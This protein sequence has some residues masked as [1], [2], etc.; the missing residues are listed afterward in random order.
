MGAKINKTAFKIFI[1]FTLSAAVIATLLLAIN[2]LG[3]SII[4]T[5]F[6]T[7]H[8]NSPEYILETIQQSLVK[9]KSGFELSNQ[10]ILGPDCWCILIDENGDITWSEHM[11]DDIPSHYTLNDI[12]KMTKWF[13][14]D[15]PVYV[16][17]SDYG[18]LVL[19]LPKYSVG[20]YDMVY[21]VEWIHSLP[22]KALG[23]LVLN[24]F[25]A[26][27][28]AF[29]FGAKLYHRVQILIN[30]INDLSKEKA[31][32]LKE[33]GIFRELAQ[34]INNT[35][36]AIE[37]KNLALAQR[38][39]AR[40]NWIS[41]ISH[42]I[43]TPLSLIM[44][45]SEALLECDSLND[46]NQ[47]RTESI[48]AQSIKIKKLIEDLNLTSS[49]EYDMQPLKKN[50][51]LLCPLIRRIATDILNS[52]LADN[53]IIDLDIQDEKAVISGDENL[54][55]RAIFNLLNNSIT[56]NKNGCE[57]SIREYTEGKTV[58]L[59]I[60]DNGIGIPDETLE[61]I[62]E[63]PKSAHGLGLP[64]AYR[65][66]CAHGGRFKAMNHNGFMVKI[67]LPKSFL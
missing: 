43:R 30:G 13:L 61:H 3:F 26:A 46:E 1:C 10:D 60:S 5:S 42:D 50:N 57:I 64:M 21:S 37:H 65:I 35:S 6:N 48:H 63:I 66:I 18:L 40:S 52:G 59:D 2:F 34:S 62:A 45:H 29:V 4:A 27:I 31:V 17:T 67:E 15:Y 33:K 20:K 7:Y 23:I 22:Q 39:N 14:N 12:A 41:G 19:G 24:L 8:G 16:Y 53:Y 54:L 38:D 55:E 58:H 28:L 56:H 32:H 51:I 47:K 44:G 49:L 11:P 9:S 25:L 36:L